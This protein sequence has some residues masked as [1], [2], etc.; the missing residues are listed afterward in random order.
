MCVCGWSK[1]RA[2]NWTSLTLALAFVALAG[3]NGMP[4]TGTDDEP[5]PTV[6]KPVITTVVGNGLAGENGDGLPALETALYL[7]QD[8]TLGPDG[9]LYFP[10]WNNHRIRRVIS[11]VVETVAG[12]GELGD[13]LDGPALEIQFN[14][15]TNVAFDAEGRMIVAAW[16]NSKVKRVDFTTGLIENLAG[17][18]GRSFGGDGGPGN[19]AI[20]DLPSSVVVDVNGNILISDQ[21]NYRIRLLQPDGIIFTIGGDGTPDYAGDGGRAE[22]ARL[23]SPKGQ[24][25]PPAGRITLNSSG[26]ILIADTGNHVIR[27]IDAAGIIR[28][29]AGSGVAGYSGD[30]GPAIQAQLNTPSDVAAGPDGSIYIADTMNHV[31]RVVTPDGIIDTLAGTGERGFSGDGGPADEAMLDRPY[32]LTA[33]SNGDVYVADT[34]NHRIRR[35]TAALPDDFV[36]GDGVDTTEVLVVPCT[37]DPGSICTYAGT[38]Q[39]GFNGDGIDRLHTA[40]YWPFDI[41][42]TA[43]GRQIVLDWNNHRVREILPDDTFVTILGTDFIGDGPV[44]LSDLEEPGADPLTVDLNHPMDVQEFPDGDLMVMAWH[45]HKIRQIDGE[46]GRAL[47]IMG[48]AP[49]FSGDDGPARDALV[50]QPPHG[51]LDPEGNLFFIDQRNQRIRVIYNFAQERGAA[52]ITTIVGTGEKGFNGDGAGLQTQV[53][54]PA[55]GNPEP[56]GGLALGA[57]GVLY[58]SDSHNHRIRSV[59]FMDGDFTNSIVTTLAGGSEPGYGGDGGPAV[60]AR[61]DF[62]QDMEFGPEGNLYFADTNNNRIRRIDLATGMIETVAGT[63]V[64]GYGGDGGRAMEAQLNRPFGIAFDPDGNL[65]I[66]DTFN[67]RIRKVVLEN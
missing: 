37:D 16:H 45:N 47:V 21:A 60:D 24:S 65:Y 8:V 64:K 67:G 42:F 26:E 40:L 28:T 11:G 38:G 10:D 12:T 27:L 25:A 20:L 62:P 17:T 61:I 58:F 33:A 7:P 57:D 35:I 9:N 13:A 18:G 1:S 2:W 6:S 48:A 46:T 19:E 36:S 49:G 43:S 30:G 32:G 56:S 31:V 53:A 39:S 22:D 5:P 41:E 50:N 52:I 44:D 29:I 3:C 55:G 14:H 63:G 54:F 23:D 15:P 34:H 66:S 51:V 59:Q 4:G